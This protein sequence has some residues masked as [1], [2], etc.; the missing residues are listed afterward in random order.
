MMRWYPPIPLT[1]PEPT[2][3]TTIDD[4]FVPAG[5]R[6]ILPLKGILHSERY[7]G[8]DTKQFLPERWLTS[9][10]D[11]GG[12]TNVKLLSSGGVLN[13][14]GSMIFMQGHRSCVGAGL[15]DLADDALRDEANMAITRGG[16]SGK[17]SNVLHI[18]VKVL[19]GW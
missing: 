1:M 11:G 19:E 7:W 13:K 2:C 17:P 15:L 14:Y 10:D 3:D 4:M 5:T 16:L 6:L 9:C 18:K 8:P 12:G